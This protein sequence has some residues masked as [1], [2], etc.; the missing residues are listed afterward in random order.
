[1]L[2][3]ISGQTVE[4]RFSALPGSFPPL[5]SLSM[6]ASLEA[7]L[8]TSTDKVSFRRL[9]IIDLPC[10]RTRSG[11]LGVCVSEF[12]SAGLPAFAAS[13]IDDGRDRAVSLSGAEV[14]SLAPE[15]YIDMQHAC[16]TSL[17]LSTT[18]ND[19]AL[20]AISTYGELCIAEA[21]T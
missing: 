5:V 4:L 10:V 3:G 15:L 17:D 8:D 9:G 6:Q 14:C 19:D 12:P 21:K 20:S 2:A 16:Q 7:V 1:M 11:H 13:V 18:L